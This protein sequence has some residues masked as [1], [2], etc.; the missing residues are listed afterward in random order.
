MVQLVKVLGAKPGNLSWIHGVYL[1][2]EE[3]NS[4][5]LSYD[6]HLFQCIHKQ[7][8]SN[9]N[10][11]AAKRPLQLR[12]N[13]ALPGNQSS[14]LHTHIRWF[15]MAFITPA[16]EDKNSSAGLPPFLTSAQHLY[17][18]THHTHTSTHIHISMHKNKTGK[19][20]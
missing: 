2:E 12:A 5:K 1:V 11:E 8:N 9:F 10:G 19:K 17:S 13:A 15:T 3:N 18:Y 7:I 14:I 16:L 4:S 6:L 20:T